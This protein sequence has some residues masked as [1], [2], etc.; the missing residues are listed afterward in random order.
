[1]FKFKIH[2]LHCISLTV[3]VGSG[4]TQVLYCSVVLCSTLANFQ[5]NIHCCSSQPSSPLSTSCHSLPAL[6]PVEPC[7]IHK[8]CAPVTKWINNWRCCQGHSL[9][10]YIL[11]PYPHC[12]QKTEREHHCTWLVCGRWAGHSSTWQH[13]LQW[14]QSSPRR[15]SASET[16]N[17]LKPH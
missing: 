1:M 14:G 3:L 4:L 8:A 16:L 17:P 10:S 15:R 6:L 7:Y 12:S 11:L 13:S 2:G 9:Q 5:R